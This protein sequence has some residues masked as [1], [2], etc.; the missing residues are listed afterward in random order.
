MGVV[1]VWTTLSPTDHI[2]PLQAN[3]WAIVAQVLTTVDH[4]DE[5][6]TAATV[7]EADVTRDVATTTDTT[8]EE[9]A[10]VA[11]VDIVTTDTPVMTAAVG[12]VAT[13]TRSAETGGIARTLLLRAMA[14][15][16]ALVPRGDAAAI[17]LAPEAQCLAG[18]TTATRMVI[19]LLRD[20]KQGHVEPTM[21]KRLGPTRL[22][23]PKSIP[24]LNTAIPSTFPKSINNLQNSPSPRMKT[25]SSN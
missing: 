25:S 15:G 7:A 16:I 10:T 6:N 8:V 1:S 11:V 9:I 22:R 20:G 21:A 13:G 18:T 23:A 24:R 14:G 17:R 3:I 19:L 2:L 5:A 4:L 12:I